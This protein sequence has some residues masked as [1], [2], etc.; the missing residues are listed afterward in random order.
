MRFKNFFVFIIFFL[1]VIFFCGFFNKKKSDSIYIGAVFPLSGDYYLSGHDVYNG[2][3]F[4][5][6]KRQKILDKNLKLKIIDCSS[7]HIKNINAYNKLSSDQNICA[8]ISGENSILS[9]D[10]AAVSQKNPL[11]IILPTASLKSITEY[12]ENIFRCAFIDETQGECMANFAL[13]DLKAKTAAVFYDM[14]NQYSVTLA[15]SFSKV[16]KQH[17]KI[18]IEQ[19]HPTDDNDYKIQLNKIKFKNPDVLFVPDY[20]YND[21]LIKKQANDIGIKSV[22]LGGDTWEKVLNL[23]KNR[24]AFDNIYFCTHYS[25]ENPD[26]KIKNFVDEYKKIYKKAPN[27]FN[28]LGFDA[29]NILID[30]IQDANSTDKDLVIKSLS[31]TNYSGITGNIKFNSERN[32]DKD[33]T[34]IKISN[35]KNNFFK[36]LKSDHE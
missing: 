23:T 10:I 26:S 12:G 1:G 27:S 24:E 31:K 32:P 15:K 21:V 22:I 6:S 4:A 36:T 3:K 29:A 17:G 7:D 18:L 33:L 13:N 35:G 11:P 16:F 28:A 8:I 2:V 5:F 34:I 9:E 19:M 30:A 14:D 25:A 20:E